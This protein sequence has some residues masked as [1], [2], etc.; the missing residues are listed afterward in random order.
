VAT[1]FGVVGAVTAWLGWLT[2]C[3]ALGFPSL[4]TAAMLNR[5]LVPKADPGSWLGWALLLIG[6]FTAALVYIAAATRGRFRPS[7]ASG[8]VYGAICWLIA[9]AVVMPLLGLADP[10]PA[11]TAPPPLNPPDPMHG[12]FM[13]LHLGVG[14]PI[15]ALVAWLVFG[16]VLGVAAGSYVDDPRTPQRLAFGAAVA[17]VAVLV[18]GLVG[19]VLIT[20]VAGSSVTGTRTLATEQAQTLPA[21]TDYFSVLELTQPPGATLG[22]HAHPYAGFADSVRGVATIDF[23]DGQTIRVTPDDVGFIG[24]QAAHSHRNTDDQVPSA[25]LALL[26]VGL[27]VAV[28][29]TWFRPGRRTARLLL[30]ALILLIAAGTLGAM[31]PWSNDWLFLSVRAVSQRGGP[32]PLPT[33]SRLFESSDLGIVDGTSYVQ[34]LEEITIAPGASVADVLSTGP[35]LLLVV[36]GQIGVQSAGGPSS[37]LGARGATVVQ[38][39]ESIQLTNAGATAAHVL[40]FALTP[41]PPSA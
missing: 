24:T 16:A 2:V 6:L 7:L 33:T 39:G 8:L 32:M 3:P 5:V 1:V 14:A 31:N 23:G 22:P 13:M 11:S 29:L 21:G 41:A 15:A 34:T 9:G 12:S 10:T 30:V 37:Q 26:I 28:G 20:P 4:A 19:L 25:L 35:A 38:T 36:D 27:A 17:A 40:K 18:A